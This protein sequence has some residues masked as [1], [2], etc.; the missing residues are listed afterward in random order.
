MNN[1]RALPKDIASH[2]TEAGL[3]SSGS[4]LQVSS[5]ALTFDHT[6]LGDES[7]LT[8]KITPP[9]PNTLIVVSV[10][11]SS[12]FQVAAGVERLAYKQAMTFKP[13]PTG[14]YIHLRYTPE[15]AGRHQAILTVE[16]PATAETISIPM[17]GRTLGI[18]LPAVNLLPAGEQ[19]VGR[20]TRS[21]ATS[22]L[23]GSL[24]IGISCAGYIYRCDLW[25]GL[26]AASSP[27][28]AS[29][30]A[31]DA[32]TNEPVTNAATLSPPTEVKSN[33][34]VTRPVATP[35]K[36][37]VVASK[38][39]EPVKQTTAKATRTNREAIGRETANVPARPA[40][41]QE[42]PATT[43]RKETVITKPAAPQRTQPPTVAPP[44]PAAK[45]NPAE[46]SELERVL[47]R[48]TN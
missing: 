16:S 23:I 20:S 44:K 15:R 45:P 42:T 3:P 9:Q 29:E 24:A 36:R 4:R 17:A 46:E 28:S 48:G 26:C 32:L 39:D 18:A 33:K 37:P 25:P 19:L 5:S 2:S 8:L 47:N 10:D 11:E 21:L 1:P 43:L 6:E 40:K 27:S 31:K 7:Y 13:E 38:P 41:S 12:M 22:V 30:P 35:V 34:P 14:S